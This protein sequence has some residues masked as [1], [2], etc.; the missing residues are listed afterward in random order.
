LIVNI[1]Q[2]NSLGQVQ[3]E[4][5][6]GYATLWH[7]TI[8]KTP[9]LSPTTV[10]T[11]SDQHLSRGYSI[12]HFSCTKNDQLVLTAWFKCKN[13][14]LEILSTGFADHNFI[15]QHSSL[16]SEEGEG[17]FRELIIQLTGKGYQLVWR[18][19]PRFSFLGPYLQSINYDGIVTIPYSFCPIHRQNDGQAVLN[20]ISN[21]KL[22][23]YKRRLIKK[24]AEF[25]CIEDDFELRLWVEEFTNNHIVRWNG[26]KTPSKYLNQKVIVQLEARFQAWIEDGVLKRFSIRHEGKRIAFCVGLQQEKQLI[27]HAIA[28]DRDYFTFSPGK[29]LILFIA[30]HMND[31][32]LNTLDFG[33]GNEAYKHSFTNNYLELDLVYISASKDFVF[34][35]K[36]KVNKFIRTRQKLY[37]ALKFIKMKFR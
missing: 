3:E 32:N 35:L 25:E 7:N 24:G 20:A 9:F 17:L 11:L 8:V 10:V 26:S 5:Q 37:S 21:K 18:N 2:F 31:E 34:L 22:I 14:R 19:F 6:K 33:E 23:Y 1:N 28:Y 4:C 12:V 30:E 16:T 15:I 13:H 27:Y 36:A 29:A